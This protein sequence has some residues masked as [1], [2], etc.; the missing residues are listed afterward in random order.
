MHHL[1]NVARARLGV[2]REIEILQKAGPAA[3][4][5]A[6]THRTSDG[7]LLIQL[8]GDLLER[9]DDDGVLAV[10]GHEIGHHLAHGPRGMSGVDPFFLY[11]I[12]AGSR[13]IGHRELAAAYCRAAEITADRIGLIACRNPEAVVRMATILG[14]IENVWP[15]EWVES[16]RKSRMYAEAVSNR[17]R[18]AI[19]DSHPEVIIRIYA[20]WLFSESDVYRAL[21]GL[22][23][24]TCSLE[25]IDSRLHALIGPYAAAEDRGLPPEGEPPLI[26]RASDVL[27]GAAERLREAFTKTIRN[28]PTR[29]TVPRARRDNVDRA[30]PDRDLL[31]EASEELERELERETSDDL[32]RRFAELERSSNNSESR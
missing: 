8:Q 7:P 2:S 5:N 11:H 10:L 22:G 32:E 9:L 4:L 24:A 13:R 12:L 25:E 21:T 23:P 17:H 16:I 29:I 26:D 28:V 19:G 31:K 15:A 20:T 3:H 30:D 6:A 14:G 1:A 27:T 18:H